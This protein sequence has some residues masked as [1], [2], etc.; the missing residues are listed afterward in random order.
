[1]IKEHVSEEDIQSYVLKESALEQYALQHIQTCAS[2]QAKL[3]MYESLFS[4]VGEMPKPAFDFDVAELV[5]PLLSVKKRKVNRL[6]AIL[7][8]LLVLAGLIGLPFL[9]FD[10]KNSS[11]LQSVSPWLFGVVG[12][13]AVTFIVISVSDMYARYRRQLKELNFE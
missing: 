11:G 4:G 2:C 10:D 3:N 1:M 5:M 12:I 8:G 13:V 7:S 9:L 6:P